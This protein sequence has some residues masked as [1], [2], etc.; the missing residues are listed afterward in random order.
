M[1]SDAEQ[2]LEAIKLQSKTRAKKYYDAHKEEIAERRKAKRILL[3]AKPQLSVQEQKN[4]EIKNLSVINM[5]KLINNTEG[6]SDTS[7]KSYRSESIKLARILNITDFTTAFLDSKKVIEKIE[8]AMKVTGK[9][10]TYSINS[11]KQMYQSILKLV[12]DIMKINIPNKSR[13]DY[14]AKFETTKFI[15]NMEADANTLDNEVMDYDEYLDM[16]KKRYGEVSKEYIIASLYHLSGFRDDLQLEL[17]PNE[18][19]ETKAN[20]KRNYLVVNQKLSGVRY[21][22][23]LNHYKTDKKYESDT[24]KIPVGLSNIIKKYIESKDLHYGDYLFGDKKL[25]STIIKFNRNMNLDIGINQLRQMR[26]SKHLANGDITPEK[27]V[28]LAMEMK[29]APQTTSRYKRTII[30]KKV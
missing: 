25:S 16:V 2:R 29:H 28:E 20:I 24:I 21:T 22:M 9:K 27:R 1:P 11:K 13:K 19:P 6:L 3:K 18:T 30:Q 14:T 15:S 12:D 5:I 23:I 4:E 17:I 26:V 8:K 7:K 10:D